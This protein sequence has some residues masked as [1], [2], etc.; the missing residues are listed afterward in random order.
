MSFHAYMF[1][2]Y[3]VMCDPFPWVANAWDCKFRATNHGEEPGEWCWEER[4]PLSSLDSPSGFIFW[5]KKV[6]CFVTKF[7]CMSSHMFWT[8]WISIKFIICLLRWRLFNN[9]KGQWTEIRCTLNIYH[10]RVKK[11][12]FSNFTWLYN[13]LVEVNCVL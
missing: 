1:V 11:N 6:Y 8:H 7:H 2:V 4:M 10:L 3:K 5:E 12:L 13:H 9:F